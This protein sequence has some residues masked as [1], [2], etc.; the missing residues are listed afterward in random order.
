MSNKVK[1]ALIL[2]VTAAVI[3]IAI[4][5]FRMNKAKKEANAF[6][7]DKGFIIQYEPAGEIGSKEALL[8]E[9]GKL[10][11]WEEQTRPE[12]NEA[13]GHTD[14]EFHSGK[15]ESKTGYEKEEEL[16]AFAMREKWMDL[17][18]ELDRNVTDAIS[19]IFERTDRSYGLDQRT[20]QTCY[21]EDCFED[22]AAVMQLVESGDG[23]KAYIRAGRD[24]DDDW[25]ALPMDIACGLQP[26]LIMAGC[27][28][29]LLT[30]VETHDADSVKW[31]VKAAQKFADRYHVTVDG[32]EDAKNEQK[33]LE[34]ANKP[35][36]PA[37][38]MSTSKARSTKL[39]APTKT[40]KE[41]G[42]WAHKVH[43][44]G[45]MYW[46]RGE[47]QIFRAHY[48]DGEIT[49]V[50][51][52]RNYTGKSP[53]TGSSGKSSSYSSDPDDHDIE[54]Y[55]EDNLDEYDSYEDAYEGFLEDEGAWDDY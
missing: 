11:R 29:A 9:I 49:A 35:E 3:L 6:A 47:R 19:L 27:E 12:I 2:L 15:R 43:T 4:S 48:Y 26:E 8:T 31:A 16:L 18:V 33:R 21:D 52:S 50:Y 7:E 22:I 45:D 30:A 14:K 23:M 54:A 5:V 41:T 53:W 39:G 36:I 44:Y 13:F 46:Y 17:R 51:D 37:V 1:A 24:L 34:Y 25:S 10:A 28:E 55:Y 40:T 42:S 20:V 32:L 38:G